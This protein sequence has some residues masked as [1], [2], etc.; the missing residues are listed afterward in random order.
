M[1]Y[2]P[3][4]IPTL[5]RFEH[6]KRC[7]E[8]LAK[9]THAANTELII[10]LDY[11]AKEEH[12][13]GYNKINSYIPNISGFKKITLFRRESNYGAEANSIDLANYA[14]SKYD[15]YIYTEDDNEFSPCFLDF[16]NKA[17][18]KYKDEMKVIS[19]C[20]FLPIQYYHI[21]ENLIFK[22]GSSAYG[23]GLWKHK[24]ALYNSIPYSYWVNIFKDRKRSLKIFLTCPGLYH[25]FD[26]MIINNYKW[27]D[28]MRSCYQI[29]NNLYQIT[30]NKSM[31]RNWGNDGTGL[32]SGNDNGILSKQEIL[33]NLV[34]N[35]EN[36]NVENSIPFLINFF[37]LLPASLINRFIF[38]IKI[39]IEFIKHH[40]KFY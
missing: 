23:L 15:A 26:A 40:V 32:H 11:P 1:N 24:E 25:M 8:S 37:D 28:V 27:D 39:L 14:F 33:S 9:N 21:S 3:V 35:L 2:Y 36:I 30:P 22:K 5:C 4:A 16:M 18:I 19:V 6:F 29:E 13:D 31:V 12:W 20:G 34:Y 7:V 10:G 17:L 38:L